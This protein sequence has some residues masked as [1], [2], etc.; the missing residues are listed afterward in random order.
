MPKVIMKILSHIGILILLFSCSSVKKLAINQSASL[1]KDA[2]KGVNKESSYD[3]FKESTLPNLKTLEGLHF[4]NP[5]NE[6]LL[7]LLIKGYTGY[8]FGIVETENYSDLLFE[9]T[10]TQGV[11]KL[12]AAYTR[13]IDY[14]I[15]YFE[16]KGIKPEDLFKR[17]GSEKVLKA[18][19]GT[20]DSDEKNALF[21]TAQALGGIVS[22]EKQNMYLL[23]TANLIKTMVDIVCNKD[24]NFENG[25]C[26][27]FY[28]AYEASRPKMMGGGLEKAKGYFL[29][30]IEKYPDNLLAQLT[31]M[32]YYLLPKGEKKIFNRNMRKLSRRFETFDQINNFGDKIKGPEQLD[33]NFNLFNAIA[34]ERYKKLEKIK[35]KLF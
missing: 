16:L 12:K 2:A 17:S 24:K 26:N 8:A 19:K 35:N 28:G 27:M 21:Y 4:A 14:G 1:F 18:F 34:Y 20:E 15:K 11:A 3:F 10:D 30:V 7:V 13:A 5:E 9:N 25:A 6:S 29:K 22:L 31:Y 33:E 23:T 32:Q